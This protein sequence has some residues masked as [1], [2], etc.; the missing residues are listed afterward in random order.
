MIRI[1]PI[2]LMLLVLPLPLAAQE[3]YREFERG[4]HL[5]D[6]QRTQ[7]DGIKRKY[8]DE[9]RSLKGESMRKRL[10]LREVNR[11]DQ[12]ERVQRELEQIEVSKQRL[13]RRYS[14]E[15]STVFSEEQRDRFYK[16]RDRENRRP[17]N[18]PGYRMHER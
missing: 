9:W 16:F 18:P 15:V 13:F 11:P 8:V 7:V 4:L 17:M 2:A 6:S 3:S 1:W 10:E 5:S 12:R 14:E